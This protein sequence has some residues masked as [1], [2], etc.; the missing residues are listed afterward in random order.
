[1][2]PKPSA[3]KEC[4]EELAHLL[5]TSYANQSGIIYTT[6]VKECEE[7]REQLRLVNIVIL[8][9]ASIESFIRL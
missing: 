2:R 9:D 3:M 1:M 7:L 8:P 5:R 6:T 4:V